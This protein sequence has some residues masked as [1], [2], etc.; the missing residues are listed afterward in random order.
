MFGLHS[1]YKTLFWNSHKV[2]TYAEEEE[3]KSE[4]ASLVAAT[5]SVHQG[6]LVI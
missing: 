1:L 2:N 4:Y 3:P 6:F 5:L